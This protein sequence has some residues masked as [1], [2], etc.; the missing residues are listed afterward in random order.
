MKK[1]KIV[2]YMPEQNIFK[3]GVVL[4]GVVNDQLQMIK[5]KKYFYNALCLFV[6]TTR[7][8]LKLCKHSCIYLLSNCG[9]PSHVQCI[10]LVKSMF[11]LYFMKSFVMCMFLMLWLH[12]SSFL[13]LSREN[14]KVVACNGLSKI[15]KV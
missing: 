14:V 2:F 12:F 11:T 3:G 4:S 9:A 8:I 1:R 15:L 6:R 5:E 7:H 10:A 13:V